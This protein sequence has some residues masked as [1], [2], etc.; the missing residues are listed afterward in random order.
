MGL[1]KGQIK[2]KALW[3][4]IKDPMIGIGIGITLILYVAFCSWLGSVTKSLALFVGL[5][6]APVLFWVGWELA[7]DYKREKAKLEYYNQ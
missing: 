7:D 6:I 1:T 5:I 4:T 2:R 3:N